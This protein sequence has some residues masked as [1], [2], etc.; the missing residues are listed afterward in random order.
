MTPQRGLRVEM[1]LCLSR[2]SDACVATVAP[3]KCQ[4]TKRLVHLRE[5]NVRVFDRCP[6]GEYSG[7]YEMETAICVS[8]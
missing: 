8:R 1:I 6:P 7:I 3:V 4:Y 5:I 2:M